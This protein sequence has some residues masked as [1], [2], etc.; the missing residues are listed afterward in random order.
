MPYFC[1]LSFFN[2]KQ[3]REGEMIQVVVFVYVFAF[4]FA[5]NISPLELC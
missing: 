5:L 4:N 3:Y 2:N 1:L